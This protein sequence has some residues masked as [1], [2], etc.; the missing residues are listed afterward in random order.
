MEVRRMIESTSVQGVVNSLHALAERPD[1]T[2]TLN[3]ISIPTL[4][5]VGDEDKLTPPSDAQY[6][7][8]RLHHAAPL[9][10][11]PHAG[12]LSPLENPDAFNLALSDFL[13]LKA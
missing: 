6:M 7:I 13:H 5:V 8:D 1:S 2:D 12:H 9:V 11:I 4:V 3:T 10:V